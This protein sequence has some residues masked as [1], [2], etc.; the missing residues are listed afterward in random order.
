[1]LHEIADS[2][3][4]SIDLPKLKDRSH[5]RFVK[6]HIDEYCQDLQGLTLSCLTLAGCKRNRRR[7]CKSAHMNAS[8]KDG[9]NRCLDKHEGVTGFQ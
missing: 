8:E 9:T 6:S 3:T 1:M 5:V 2:H 4:H 7:L